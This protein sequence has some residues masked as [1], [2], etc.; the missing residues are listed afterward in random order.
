MAVCGDLACA[1]SA[2]HAPCRDCECDP[3]YCAQCV[4]AAA[5]WNAPRTAAGGEVAPSVLR[6]VIALADEAPKLTDRELR[7]RL[8]ALAD[9]HDH[10]HH[11]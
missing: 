10:R 7:D 8:L 2:S 1:G 6:Q 11:C 3:V 5:C 4:A 9:V